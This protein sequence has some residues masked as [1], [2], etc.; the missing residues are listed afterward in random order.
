MIISN[1]ILFMIKCKISY[2]V[3]SFVDKNIIIIIKN[4]YILRNDDFFNFLSI[5]KNYLTMMYIFFEF[6]N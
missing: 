1:L 6:K 4:M 2:I 5:V 3:L